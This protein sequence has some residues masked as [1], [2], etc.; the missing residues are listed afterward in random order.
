MTAVTLVSATYSLAMIMA[1]TPTSGT[2]SSLICD[3]TAHTRPT[4]IYFWLYRTKRE[5]NAEME[6]PRE[7]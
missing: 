1:A 3:M 2:E 4:S 6:Y 7:A 5:R